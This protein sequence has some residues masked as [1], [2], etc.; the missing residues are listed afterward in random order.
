M[1]EKDLKPGRDYIGVGVGAVVI[2]DRRILL[3]LRKKSPEAGCWS[4]PGG[5]VEFMETCEHAI[6]R[7]LE[8]ETGLK[9]EIITLLGVTNHILV[10]ERGHFVAPSFLVTANGEPEN[11]EPGSH[12]G[13]RWFSLDDLPENITMTTRCA[14]EKYYQY[15][16]N[17]ERS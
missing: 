4:I 1:T 17:V 9:G 11:R 7:E 3:L 16:K 2:R 5:K 8:E 10:K 14:L 13:I 12:D 6:L 15:L